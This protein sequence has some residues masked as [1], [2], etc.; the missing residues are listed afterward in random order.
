MKTVMLW[1]RE[2]FDAL[3][4]MFRVHKVIHRDIKPEKYIAFEHLQYFFSIFVT[5]EFVLKIGDFGLAKYIEK[6]CVGSFAGTQR[7]MSPTRSREGDDL[8]VGVFGLRH[9]FLQ[10]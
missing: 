7:Y 10:N 1:S 8:R 2:L 9:V 4:Y 3:D 5:M 6:T